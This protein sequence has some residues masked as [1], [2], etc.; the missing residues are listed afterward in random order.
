MRTLASSINSSKMDTLYAF[1][2][3]IDVDRKFASDEVQVEKAW[4]RQLT[5]Q[6]YLTAAEGKELQK[7]LSLAADLILTDSFPW[8]LEDEDIHMN[9]ERFLVDRIGNIG[10]KLHLGSA[11]NDLIATSLRLR[12]SRSTLTATSAVKSLIT[13]LIRLAEANLHVI[14][15]GM[16]HLQNGQPIR[17]AQV[18][19]AYGY[20]LLSDLKRFKTVKA[21]CL[22]A[23]PLGS[24]AFAGTPL[25]IDRKELAYE[26]GFTEPCPNCYDGVGDRD[27]MIDALHAMAMVAIHMAKIC[28]DILYWTS[29][30]VALVIIPKNWSTGSS[31]MPNQRNPHV[32]ELVRARAAGI[33]A[34]EQGGKNV[35][36]GFGT[37][38]SG[39]LH[40]LKKT[41]FRVEEDF[42]ASAEILALFMSEIEIDEQVANQMCFKG[43][44]LA[45][46]LANK[47]VAKGDTFRDAYRKAAEEVTKATAAGVQV[48]E[49][50]LFNEISPG[51]GIEESVEERSAIGGTAKFR[52]E[53][54]LSRLRSQLVKF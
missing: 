37:S 14:V 9:I 15:P 3:G 11:R 49:A 20:R 42:L 24:A 54:S 22:E 51:Y 4:A 50:K 26:L 36:R 53:E 16:S 46:D 23:M 25:T 43:H 40:E 38:Y 52:V 6:G 33:M 35:L 8:Q 44:I 21:S 32:L 30:N 17:I 39:D 28:E 45:T 18:F 12:V 2:H 34:A 10:K 19:S 5:K 7:A 27:F 1:T 41:F 31:M 29:S 47:L 48:C 13:V